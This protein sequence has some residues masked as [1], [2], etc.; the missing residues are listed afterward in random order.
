M[1]LCIADSGAHFSQQAWTRI[2]RHPES[3][4]GNGYGLKN[5]ERRLCLYYTRDSVMH[6]DL[7]DPGWS[8][9]VIPLRSV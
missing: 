5:V 7:S 9:I 4:D 2:F 1:E 6:L 8:V 3:F